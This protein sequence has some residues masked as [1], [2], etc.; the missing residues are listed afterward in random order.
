MELM[1]CD[2][3]RVLAS[4]QVLTEDH[5]KVLLKQLLLGVQAMHSHG[6][7]RAYTHIPG[8]SHLCCTRTT[9]LMIVAA[10]S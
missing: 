7:I 5:V 1:E 6:I 9:L 3:Q 2:L 8:R 4:R 10:Q